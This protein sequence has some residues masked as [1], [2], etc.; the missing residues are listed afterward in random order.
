[1]QILFKLFTGFDDLKLAID[2]QDLSLFG[3][4]QKLIAQ[5]SVKTPNI[6]QKPEFIQIDLF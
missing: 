5:I 4:R 1:M 2:L 6:N 3:S